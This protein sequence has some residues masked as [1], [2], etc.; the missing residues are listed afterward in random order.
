MPDKPLLLLDVD[1][2]C[3]PFGAG[4]NVPADLELV[5]AGDVHVLLGPRTGAH[6]RALQS[7]FELC[8][9]SGWEERANTYICPLLGLPALAVI[10]LPE[11]GAV[12]WDEDFVV[13]GTWKLH[14]VSE[15]VG[16]RPLA[17]IDD[18]LQEDAFEWAR[19]RTAAGIPTLL[20]CPEAH[21]G[22]SENDVAELQSFAAGL[23]ST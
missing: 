17:W 14:A 4:E 15:A 13:T 9:A 23:I 20:I 16:G 12:T 22:M 5:L 11:L 1:G 8:W 18:E 10:L 7:R 3:C 21:Q 19:A 2:V 6:V